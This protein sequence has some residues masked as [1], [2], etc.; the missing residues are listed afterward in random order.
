VTE[1]GI[2]KRAGLVLKIY[3]AHWVFEAELRAYLVVQ[4]AGVQFIPQLLG[5]FNVPG[6]KGAMLLTLVGKFNDRPFTLNDR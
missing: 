3:H 2:S 4:K 5:V 1:I 6:T